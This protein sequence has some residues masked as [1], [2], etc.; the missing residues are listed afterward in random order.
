M[1]R[2]SCQLFNGENKLSSI[3]WRENKLSAIQW[4][5]NKLSAIQWREQVAFV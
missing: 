3:Q 5:E 2:T 4:R 1:A